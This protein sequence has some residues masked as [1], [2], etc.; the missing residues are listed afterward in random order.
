MAGSTSMKIVA[1]DREPAELFAALRCLPR[2]DVSV[3]RLPLGDVLVEDQLLV[4]RKTLPDF[5]VSVMDGRLFTQ[6]LR[7]AR[8]EKRSV[9][10]LEGGASS[11]ARSGLRRE[12]L[13]GAL[14]TL[15]LIYGIP[16]LRS[17]NP[18]ETARLIFFAES[19]RRAFAT[20]AVHRPG[21]RPK[22]KRRRQIYILQG[23]PGIGPARAASLLAC[24]GSVEST[25]EADAASLAQV[26]GIG[27]KTAE[28]IRWSVSDPGASYA[29][30]RTR[31]LPRT[32]VWWDCA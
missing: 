25:F 10:I 1:D 4:E 14:I 28:A 31:L 20:E 15:S 11:L 2:A 27:K 18:E 19:Q 23:L 8:G 21:Y 29:A 24:F 32:H 30:S 12:A 9:V 17:A 6:A 5:A 7:L 16:V 26:P 13:Q 22:G 3:A